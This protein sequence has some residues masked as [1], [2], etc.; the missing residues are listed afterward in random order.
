[1][2]SEKKAKIVEKMKTTLPLILS[3][4]FLLLALVSNIFAQD[5]TEW[6][7]PEGAIARLGIGKGM[8]FEIQFSPDNKHLAVASSAGIWLYD[9]VTFQEVVLLTG[10]TD[11][12]NSVSFSPDGN[13]I[14]SGQFGRYHPSVGC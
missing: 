5:Y 10:H 13:T 9:A 1:M 12:V 7:L 3:I 2:D 14:A 6:H 11:V 4:L 8:I